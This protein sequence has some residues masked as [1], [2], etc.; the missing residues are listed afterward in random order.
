M[1]GL[2]LEHGTWSILCPGY[3]W[4]CSQQKVDSGCPAKGPTVR[5]DQ[6]KPLRTLGINERWGRERQ[7]SGGTPGVGGSREIEEH[8]EVRMMGAEEMLLILGP[9]F[10]YK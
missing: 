9:Q 2:G 1:C 6:N 7:E 5:W 10:P 8:L 4:A 3:I